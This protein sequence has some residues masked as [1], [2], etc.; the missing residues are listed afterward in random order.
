MHLQL[1]EDVTDVIAHAG[2]GQPQS[3]RN[4]PIPEGLQPFQ[5]LQFAGTE[6][7]CVLFAHLGLGD[8][9]GQPFRR[10]QQGR[11]ELTVVGQGDS[12]TGRQ[13]YRSRTN[14]LA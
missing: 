6:T 12:G 13:R 3:L 4:L 1:S 7:R 14:C 5:H 9:V 11:V 8:S 10:G 2:H